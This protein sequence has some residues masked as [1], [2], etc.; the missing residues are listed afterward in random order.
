[1]YDAGSARS[2]ARPK[3]LLAATR[4]ASAVV[5]TRASVG[6][7]PQAGRSVKQ[8]YMLS[9]M[10]GRSTYKLTSEEIVALYRLT[11]ERVNSSGAP[12]D[13]PTLIERTN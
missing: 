3:A 13:D 4:R 1:M 7:R 9:G 10:C 11:F 8:R 2:K 6:I 12:D 5:L